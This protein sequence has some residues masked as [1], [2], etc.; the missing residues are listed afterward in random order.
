[1]KRITLST[2]IAALLCLSYSCTQPPHYTEAQRSADSLALQA[3]AA[4][5]AKQML[6]HQKDSIAAAEAVRAKRSYGPCPVAIKKCALA[7][8][9]NGSKAII[10]TVKNVSSRK[11]DAVKLAWTVYNGK[12]ERIGGSSGMAKKALLKGVTGSYAWAVNAHS[13]ASAKASVAAIHY[14]DGSVWMAD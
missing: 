13:G 14:H 9:P 1:M 4:A 5:L 7:V 11:I 12:G 3:K 6:Q 8:Q 10:V 2:I